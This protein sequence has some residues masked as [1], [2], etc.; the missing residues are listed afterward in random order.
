MQARNS[1]L[2][3]QH[4]VSL[5]QGT[6]RWALVAVDHFLSLDVRSKCHLFGLSET[7]KELEKG[8]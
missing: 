5:S 1:V 7:L 4:I 6:I 8:E 3:N 2:L